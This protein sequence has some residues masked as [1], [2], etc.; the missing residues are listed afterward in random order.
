MRLFV[1][2]DIDDAT[3]SGLRSAR[4]SI[5]SAVAAAKRPPR[6][7]WVRDDAAHVTLRFIGETPDAQV[8]AVRAALAG[9]LDTQNYR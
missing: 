8:N 4:D 1:A 3:R 9:R 5:A 6:I 2:V 7:T